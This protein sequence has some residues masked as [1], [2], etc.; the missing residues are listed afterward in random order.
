MGVINLDCLSAL[1]GGESLEKGSSSPL[2]PLKEHFTQAFLS[3]PA[4]SCY[5]DSF[6]FTCPGFE[7]LDFIYVAQ[8]TGHVKTIQLQSFH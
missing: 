2:T 3:F 5:T 8:S 7:S 1:K 6:G 4:V